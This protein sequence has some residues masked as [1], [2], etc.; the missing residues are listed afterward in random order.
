LTLWYLIDLGHLIF[1]KTGWAAPAPIPWTSLPDNLHLHVSRRLTDLS[2]E[3][4]MMLKGKSAARGLVEVP[5][6]LNLAGWNRSQF[7]EMRD[8]VNRVYPVFVANEHEIDPVLSSNILASI[9][10]K[11][12]SSAE[13]DLWNGRIA[14]H[15]AERSSPTYHQELAELYEA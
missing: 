1:S 10:E 8:E 9:R 4:G 2:P 5:E 6:L 12:T 7:D 13:S 14:D 3:T 11:C 15:L